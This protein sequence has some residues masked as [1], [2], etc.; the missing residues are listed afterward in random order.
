MPRHVNALVNRGSA[1]RELKRPEESLASYELALA[2]SADNLD[3]LHGRGNM[4]RELR[5]SSDAIG[6]YDRALQVDP[7]QAE[8]HN[9]RGNAL[10]DLNRPVEALASFDAALAV[11]PD[12]LEAMINRGNVLMDM[13]RI[14]DAMA[15]YDAVLAID[16]E[17]S[18]AH[19]NKSLVWLAT[20]DYARGFEAY[21]WRARKATDNDVRV[22]AAPRW[23]G[24]EPLEGKTILLHAEQGFGDTIQFIR[25][26]PL[27]AA[28]GARIVVEAP[29]SLK[30]LI[31][32]VEGVSA[33][34]SRG[35]VD[36]NLRLAT[37][38]LMSLPLAFGTTFDTVRRPACPI[39]HAPADRIETWRGLLPSGKPL[40]VGVAWSGNQKHRNDRHRSIALEKG[41]RRS[42]PI[43]MSQFF[44]IQR[45][46]TDDGLQGAA[47][48]QFADHSARCAVGGFFRHRRGGFAARPCHLGRH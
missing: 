11:R 3:A 28:K 30:Q 39:F 31:A 43:P 47:R 5:K 1:L 36:A 21:E 19:W 33:V 17:H 15:S 26:A 44:G 25:Y 27:V 42:P 37:C 23:N 32:G 46:V 6:S 45:D 4:L 24:A 7:R 18:E 9:N 41:S 35:E 20:G 22:F 40:R 38:P 12:Y 10:S 34:V 8:V 13:R 48:T 14:D 2:L 16:P 29:T